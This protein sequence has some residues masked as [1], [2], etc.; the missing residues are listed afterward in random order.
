PSVA[1][2]ADLWSDW[3]RAM[4]TVTANPARAAGLADRGRIEPGARADLI[5]F[6]MTGKTPVLRE[7]HVQGRRVA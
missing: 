1:L 4:A 5:R 6:R 3:P 7:T 2:L